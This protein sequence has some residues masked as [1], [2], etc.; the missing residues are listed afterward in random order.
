MENNDTNADYRKFIRVRGKKWQ[1]IE[2]TIGIIF[3]AWDF[4]S[5]LSIQGVFESHLK[6][7]TL[8]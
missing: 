7:I 5:L 1:I 4:Y 3:F 8:T 2:I 6:K